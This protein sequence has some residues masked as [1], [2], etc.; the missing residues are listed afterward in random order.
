MSAIVEL[1]DVSFEYSPSQPVLSNITAAV[2][3]GQLITLMGPNGVGKSTML[4][5]LT[6]LL[7]PS[8][9]E[10]F[11]NGQ[12]IST[13]PKKTI[14][15]SIAYVPQ[16]S[17]VS[18]DYSVLEFVVMGRA[19]HM[20]LLATPSNEDYQVAEAALKELE[21]ETL[22]NRPISELSGGEQQ[23]ACI[24]RAIAQNPR[25]IIMDEP[26]SAL[27]YGNVVTVLRLVKKLSQKGYAVLITTHN[28][29]HTLLLNSEV[30]LLDRSGKL[31]TGTTE[32]LITSE[33]L[34]ALYET[35]I[36]VSKTKDNSRK[37]CFLDSL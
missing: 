2:E 31:R 27:D 18:F 19:A 3:E 23:K 36:H 25:M 12:K 17:A 11:L 10:V 13:L 37:I 6:G 30:W 34:S 26:T 22:K 28:P 15:R 4:N 1:H 32:E 5:C 7:R 8:K 9:G 16:H 29:E 35:P 14:A 24:A 21:L 20:N 33:C